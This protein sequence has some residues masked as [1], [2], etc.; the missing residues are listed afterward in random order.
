MHIRPNL[1]QRRRAAGRALRLR[2]ARHAHLPALALLS[3]AAAARLLAR[4]D[5]PAGGRARVRVGLVR[6][7][8][9][10]R[11]AAGRYAMRTVFLIML[12]MMII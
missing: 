2:A 10:D 9:A 11:A 12:I 8:R 7:A 4:Q 5:S 1:A 3:A 6:R